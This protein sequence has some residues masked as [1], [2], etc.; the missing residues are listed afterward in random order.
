MEFETTKVFGERGLDAP[1]NDDDFI[2]ALQFNQT[3]NFL[4][5]GD[6]SGRA[7]IF[8][9]TNKNQI[10]F[11]TQMHAHKSE[12]DYLRSVLSEPRV[13]AIRW[14]PKTDLNPLFLTTNMH[15]TKLWKL[16]QTPRPTWDNFDQNQPN[17]TFLF[18]KLKSYEVKYEAVQLKKFF[19]VETEFLVSIEALYD[20]TSFLMVDVGC[21]RLWDM[22]RDVPPVFTYRTNSSRVELTAS[23]VTNQIPYAILISDDQGYIK[24]LD[25]RQQSSN[26]SAAATMNVQSAVDKSTFT[27]GCQY[28]SS[29]RFLNDGV[30]FLSRIFGHCM[31][32][33]LRNPS[34]A[35]AA[36]EVQSFPG[37]MNLVVH[38][39][40]CR[41]YFISSVLPTDE[42]ISG[43]YG[44]EYCVWDWKNNK[45]YD[46]I[47]GAQKVDNIDFSRRIGVVEAHPLENVVAV[48][49]S[50]ALY[51]QAKK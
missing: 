29:I 18:P 42:I 36:I 21:V 12:F 43:K 17:N 5:T 1:L 41:D 19:D 22:N 38:K 7:V 10:E 6:V 31:V 47:A 35:E 26:L 2:S 44:N 34:Q 16:T 20:Q 30:H 27:N 24:M 14:I 50:T 11:V 51:V 48:A 9:Y 46:F 4:A 25:M 32:W 3:G 8:R 28:V 15:E 33:D 39:G 13:C 45:S 49:S 37:R 23:A 40:Y